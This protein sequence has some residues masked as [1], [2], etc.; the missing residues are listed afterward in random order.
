MVERNFLNMK[1]VASKLRCSVFFVRNEVKRGK[2]KAVKFGRS[3][4]VE[5]TELDKYIDNQEV[6]K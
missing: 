5:D 6:K 3:L 1:E 4:C 2:L